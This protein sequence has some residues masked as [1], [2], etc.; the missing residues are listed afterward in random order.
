M[1]FRSK[2]K[3]L[4]E[5]VARIFA[6]EAKLPALDGRKLL[7]RSEHSALNTLLQG[8]GA[9]VMKEALVILTKRLTKEKIWFK[10]V[11][12]VH[13]EWQ[14]ECKSEDAEKIGN[15]G[16]QAITDA[17]VSFNMNCPLDGDFKIGTTWK[18]TH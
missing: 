17:G 8:A 5:K 3:A 16:K 18:M 14:I 2:L 11:A 15:Y 10:F 1:L 6:K 4:R 12:N 13:D 9:I 7:V